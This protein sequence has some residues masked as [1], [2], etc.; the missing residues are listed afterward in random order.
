V[1]GHE[2]LVCHIFDIPL[3]HPETPQRPE[4]IRGFELEQGSKV[5]R[6][7]PGFADSILRMGDLA[8][9]T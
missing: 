3:G 5:E 9:R 8:R 2:D 4:H 1:N 7:K 6:G